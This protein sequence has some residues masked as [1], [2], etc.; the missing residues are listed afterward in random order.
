LLRLSLRIYVDLFL[1][2]SFFFPSI[3]GFDYLRSFP[4]GGS[5]LLNFDAFS[6]PLLLFRRFLPHE[7]VLLHCLLVL[8]ADLVQRITLLLKFLL[9]KIANRRYCILLCKDVAGRHFETPAL[10]RVIE[11]YGIISVGIHEVH[12]SLFYELD[13]FLFLTFVKVALLSHETVSQLMLKRIE[14]IVI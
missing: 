2:V 3:A 12:F 14:K 13:L 9:I 4:R 1:S 11:D 7:I 5:L 6:S 8:F 10:G